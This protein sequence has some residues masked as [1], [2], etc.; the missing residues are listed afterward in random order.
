M[1]LLQI[2]EKES[3]LPDLWQVWTLFII[4]STPQNPFLYMA[5]FRFDLPHFYASQSI[6]FLSKSRKTATY[7][8]TSF[9]LNTI[10]HS[11]STVI[12]ILMNSLSKKGTR[13]SRP[14]ADVALLARRQSYWWRAFICQK[15][16]SKQRKW[17]I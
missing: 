3:F 16:K 12:A 15:W 4:K 5:L 9:F 11:G 6:P 10:F 17:E 14:H 8:N 13:A 7:M 2:E 1:D